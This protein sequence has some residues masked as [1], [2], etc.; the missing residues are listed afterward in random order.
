MTTV[1][2][3]GAG[4]GLG[5]EFAR[6]YAGDGA[7][8]I[9]TVRKPEA[10][11]ALAELGAKVHLLDVTDGAQVKRLAASIKDPI[12]I[13]ICNAGIFE[14]ARG[15]GLPDTKIWQDTLATNLMAPVALAHALLPLVAASGEKKMAF[16]SSRLG[17]IALSTAGG[18]VAYNTSKAALNMAVKMMSVTFG[19][20]GVT[21]LVLSP[22]WVQTDMGGAGAALTPTQSITGMRAVLARA[23]AADNGK[24]FHYDGSALPW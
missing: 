5:L 20:Q 14:G 13:F 10:G 7:T 8:V 16:V 4:R 21:C 6:Q 19:P 17:S 23:T 1:L 22:G 18:N 11:R 2:I 9:G 3:T 15:P 12:D 24:F